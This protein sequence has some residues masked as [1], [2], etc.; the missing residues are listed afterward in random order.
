[1]RILM[2][3]GEFITTKPS[4]FFPVFL[5]V[6]YDE[7]ERERERNEITTD[8][9][10]DMSPT[11]YTQSGPLFDSK[12][13][14]LTKLLTKTLSAPRAAG[15]LG[16]EPVFI[17]PT[18]PHRL[19][20][21]DIPGFVPKEA[22]A[23]D[24]DDSSDAWAWFRKNEV[25]G[26]YRGFEAGMR[27]IADAIRGDD[28]GCGD[29]AVEAADDSSKARIDGVIG[30]SQGGATAALV[31]AA[32][33]PSRPMPD[34]STTPTPSA[35]T[36]A[37]QPADWSWVTALREANNGQPVKFAVIYSG[38]YSPVPGLQWL[39]R[40]PPIQ[41]P[42]AHFIGSLD[43]VVDE[44]RSQGLVERCK[45]PQVFVHPGGHYVPVAKQWSVALVG[46]IRDVYTKAVEKEQGAASDGG[47][48]ANGDKE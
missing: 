10:D 30:F 25:D 9:A 43:T 44:S 15:G 16:V 13:K 48:A 29:D 28:N 21:Q 26:T 6:I 47:T 39:M 2:L 34:P 4:D 27:T 46:Y 20:P 33:E 45:D 23:D 24:D 14:A 1:M 7:R 22:D 32:L 38:F 19:R 40:D 3:H 41:T 35:E 17:H 11:G 5:L 12:T 31:A 36:P 42:M 37:G 8:R 18:G